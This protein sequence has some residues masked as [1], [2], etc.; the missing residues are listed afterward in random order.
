MSQ[1]GYGG[2]YEGNRRCYWVTSVP[3]EPLC[4]SLVSS[5]SAAAYVQAEQ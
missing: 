3:E 1:M 4:K 2:C 5:G